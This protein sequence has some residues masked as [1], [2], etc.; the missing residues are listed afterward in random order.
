MVRKTLGSCWKVLRE[1]VAILI[2]WSMIL[3]RLG[4]VQIVNV[5]KCS[6]DLQETTNLDQFIQWRREMFLV[7]AIAILKLRLP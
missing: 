5:G 6:L 1:C 4:R 2:S 3:R 7:V